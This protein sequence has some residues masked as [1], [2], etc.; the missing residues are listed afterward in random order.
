MTM[1]NDYFFLYL[2]LVSNAMLLMIAAVVIIGF[3]RRWRRIEEFWDSPTGAALSD[4]SDD[5]IREQMQATQRLE[6]RLAE[7]QRAVKIIDMKEPEERPP[8]ERSVP[9]ENAVRMARLGATV[10]DL[11]RNCGLNVGEARLMKT[12]HGRPPV[13][14]NGP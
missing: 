3:E 2:L 9:I 7:L 11:T 13:A 6:R 5:E 10:E 1:T 12:L 4:A 14:A 8:V